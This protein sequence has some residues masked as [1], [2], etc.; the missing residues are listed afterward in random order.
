M[1]YISQV[2]V[3]TIH[4]RHS[5]WGTSRPSH[6][7]TTTAFSLGS[8]STFAHRTNHQQ[9]ETSL[10]LKQ[11]SRLQTDRQTPRIELETNH[12]SGLTDKYVH[13][14]KYV[15][16][17]ECSHP[18]MSPPGSRWGISSRIWTEEWIP[19]PDTKSKGVLKLSPTKAPNS[20]PL[21][22]PWPV[23]I[24]LGGP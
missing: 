20:Y 19:P 24:L 15:D 17:Q 8:S 5:T 23:V 2:I 1:E 4:W 6:H 10:W 3:Q 16:G 12:L 18:Q 13:Y 7:D 21:L 9:V 11:A 14:C 22:H